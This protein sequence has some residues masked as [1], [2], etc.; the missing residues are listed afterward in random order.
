MNDEWENVRLKDVAD[1][2]L[3]KM[4][5]KSKNQGVPTAYLRNINVRWFDF[6]L[7]D[8]QELRIPASEAE[9]LSILDGDLL[10]C[11]G[12]E[13]GRC[14]IWKGGKNNFVFQKALHR[15][16]VQNGLLPQWLGYAVKHAADSGALAD[17]FTGTTIKHL[18]GIALSRFEFPLPT[19]P[20]QQ[21]IV[22]R[23]EDLFAFAE[24]IEAR[25]ATAQKTVERLTPATLAKAFR[26]ELVPQDPTD[27]PASALLAR[28][29]NQPP[30]KPTRATRKVSK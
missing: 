2:R 18:T 15:V 11:E 20:E 29:Q 19:L 22:R 21:E 9:E 25:L 7:S 26:G 30:A 17:L 27:E 28:L 1:S 5:D 3:G 16:R 12:G 6:N 10:I 14:A 24:R 23:V 13:P 4:L 8:V